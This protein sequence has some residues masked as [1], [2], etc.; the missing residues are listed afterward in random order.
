M[1]DRPGG[2]SCDLRGRRG[3]HLVPLRSLFDIC[4]A[5]K[6]RVVF[7]TLRNIQNKFLQLE[8]AEAHSWPF[9]P[10]LWGAAA[11]GGPRMPS[12]PR[13]VP[14]QPPRSPSAPL[15]SSASWLPKAYSPSGPKSLGSGEGAGPH[16]QGF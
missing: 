4:V 11:Q 1:K 16:S 9:G 3:E 10:K 8:K 6:A 7:E 13:A 2:P 12:H 14:F 15:P 5:P